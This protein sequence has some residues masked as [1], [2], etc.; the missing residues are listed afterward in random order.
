MISFKLIPVILF[1]LLSNG[2]DGQTLN[3]NFEALLDSNNMRFEA[4][5]GYQEITPIKNNA[6]NYEKAFKHPTE[7]FEVRYA[8]R[9]HNSETFRTS[10]EMTL[11]NISGQKQKEYTVFNQ[12]AVDKEFGADQGA[13]YMVQPV[14]EFSS[15]YKYCLVVGVFKQGEGDAFMFYL[16]ND[17]NLIPQLMKPIFGALQFN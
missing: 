7:D 1:V 10:F 5:E 15:T 13:T 8:V 4:P 6:L 14:P 2:I 9:H 3:S 17:N 11:E 12:E 16:A